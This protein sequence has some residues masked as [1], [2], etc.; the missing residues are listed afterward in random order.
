[1]KSAFIEIADVIEKNLNCQ[2]IDDLGLEIYIE[3]RS[4]FVWIC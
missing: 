4:S 3:C 2:F 1:M